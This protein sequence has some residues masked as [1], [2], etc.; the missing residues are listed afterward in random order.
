MNVVFD[1]AAK[2]KKHTFEF[3]K[4][5]KDVKNSLKLKHMQ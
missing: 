4:S 1:E 2:T 5:L 3:N